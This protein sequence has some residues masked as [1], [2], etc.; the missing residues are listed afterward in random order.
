M[1]SLP[2]WLVER[3]ALDEVAPASRDRVERADPHEL[4]ER[5]AALNAEN[6]AELGAYPAGVAV[7]QIE[8]RIA[9]ES[10]RRADRR[11]SVRL[12]WFGL[13]STAAVAAIVLLMVGRQT[14]T[15]NVQS[16]TDPDEEVTRVKGAARL[17]AFRQAGDHAERLE[18]DSLVQAGDMI[19][20]RYHAAGQGFGV[21]ASIDG[22]GVVTLHYPVDDDAPPRA[23]AL[24]PKTTALPT[25]YVLDN[26]PAFE[27]FFF[28][29]GDSPINVQLS[30]ACVRALAARPDSATAPLE[31]PSGLHQWSLRLR[32]PSKE[33]RQ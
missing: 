22:A 31:L 17:L 20:L 10:K 4:A 16:P 7:A 28:I 23:T 1:T 14:T 27:R 24:A 6:A 25:A 18:E 15:S 5:I 32:K 30:L 21:I 19:Q 26:A 9:V 8:Q 11:R 12:R 3:A 33:D 29:T 2:D 13:M